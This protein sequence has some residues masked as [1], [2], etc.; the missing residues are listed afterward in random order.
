MNFV[1]DGHHKLMAAHR[2]QQKVKLV[3][4]LYCNNDYHYNSTLD[5]LKAYEKIQT[6]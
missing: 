5:L 2:Q 4:F 6:S 3:I 1:L